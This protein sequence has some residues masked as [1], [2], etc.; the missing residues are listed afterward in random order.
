MQRLYFNLVKWHIFSFVLTE[1][2]LR[3]L[4]CDLTCRYSFTLYIRVSRYCVAFV[5]SI[6]RYGILTVYYLL[7]VDTPS[8]L[9]KI[10][11]WF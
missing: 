2:L 11:G 4:H 7:Y 9:R 10:V 3:L 1:I 8:S 6:L 5:V